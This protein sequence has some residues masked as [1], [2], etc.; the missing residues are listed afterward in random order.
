VVGITHC[1]EGIVTRPRQLFADLSEL[2]ITKH[3]IE[4]ELIID[5]NAHMT[6]SSGDVSSM[7]LPQLLKWLQP[8]LKPKVYEKVAEIFSENDISGSDLED[9]DASALEDFGLNKLFRKKVLEVL[10]TAANKTVAVDSMSS[11]E[12]LTYLIEQTG[13]PAAGLTSDCLSQ[14][15]VEKFSKVFRSPLF[16]AE[17]TKKYAEEIERS[18]KISPLGVQ[19]LSEEALQELSEQDKSEYF[20]SFIADTSKLKELAR[21]NMEVIEKFSQRIESYT[22]SLLSTGSMSLERQLGYIEQLSRSQQC[23]LT[24]KWIELEENLGQMNSA[25]LFKLKEVLIAEIERMKEAKMIEKEHYSTMQAQIKEI[26]LKMNKVAHSMGFRDLRELFIKHQAWLSRA[27]EYFMEKY[28]VDLN[29]ENLDLKYQGLRYGAAAAGLGVS[30]GSIAA[31]VG[32]IN[33]MHMGYAA[34]TG[35]YVLAGGLTGGVALGVIAV[36]A[37]YRQV[38]E[39]QAHATRKQNQAQRDGNSR[40]LCVSLLHSM[41]TVLVALE[42]CAKHTSA[43]QKVRQRNQSRK[44]TES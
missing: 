14:A 13:A 25:H 33:L 3:G 1:H 21:A 38:A 41:E 4:P 5:M 39:Q 27:S 11:G 26:E 7:K 24:L 30:G 36:F 43:L 15:D 37:G 10:E 23:R 9:I 40:A 16:S 19:K 29:T 34:G 6:P 12:F 31:A 20:D 35:A 28:G 2:L 8:Q 22:N 32:Y 17:V 18:F 44:V 42:V